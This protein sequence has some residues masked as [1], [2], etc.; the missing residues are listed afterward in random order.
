MSDNESWAMIGELTWSYDGDEEE[1][2]E[3]E[4]TLHDGVLTLSEN[5]SV[6]KGR[7]EEPGL[8][9][10]KRQ[11][12][13][14]VGTLKVDGI[15]VFSGRFEEDGYQGHWELMLSSDRDW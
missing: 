3:V 10:V 1:T 15:D 14:G 9:R 12:N 5:E 8:Y 7:M 11:D 2:V 6:W 13:K 4:V